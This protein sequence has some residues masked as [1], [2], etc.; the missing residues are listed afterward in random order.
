MDCWNRIGVRGDHSC[1]E[2][3]HHVHCRNCP[4]HASAALTLLDG[5][6]PQE[7]VS[8]RTRH[9]AT[10]LVASN[11]ASESVLIFRIAEEWLA[12]SATAVREVAE[13]RPIHSLPHRRA[14]SVLGIANVR[15]QLVVCVSLARMLGLKSTPD[16]PT[17]GSHGEYQR[18]L[19][20]RHREVCAASP[21]DAIYGVHRADPNDLKAP[22]AT[23]AGAGGTH[24]K[25]VM[26]WREHAVGVLDD[27]R[28]FHALERSLA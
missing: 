8:T 9:F 22:P 28:L 17:R 5:A 24:S 16:R 23:V 6:L 20:I 26:T 21:V 10:P 25:A 7:E 14:S 15:G 19:V 18:L 1:P 13:P 2:L 12:L 3:Q 4:V 11:T 27:Q